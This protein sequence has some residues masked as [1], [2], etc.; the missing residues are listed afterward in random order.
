MTWM[1][2]QSKSRDSYAYLDYTNMSRKYNLW[3]II[4]LCVHMFGIWSNRNEQTK[5]STYWWT[6]W[7]VFLSVQAQSDLETCLTR[8][9]EFEESHGE[10][11]FW[12]REAEVL[13]RSELDLKA[14]VEEKK[15]HWE[16][17]LVS[18]MNFYKF[19]FLREYETQYKHCNKKI[20]LS[21]Y[22]KNVRFKQARVCW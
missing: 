14:T 1:K 7:V 10:F 16:E 19:C 13:L 15:Q 21:E 6:T 9:D 18:L 17:Y 3:Q 20:I 12:L 11:G 5:K 2:I 8:W 22:N 4:F